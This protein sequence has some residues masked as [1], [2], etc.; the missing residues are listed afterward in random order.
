MNAVKYFSKEENIMFLPPFFNLWLTE[1]HFIETSFSFFIALL[2]ISIRR[3][4]IVIKQ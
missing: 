2:F 1:S 4:I 3:I